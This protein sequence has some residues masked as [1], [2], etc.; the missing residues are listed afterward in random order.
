MITP[1]RIFE[2]SAWGGFLI[3][4]L[5]PDATR[6]SVKPGSTL[7]DVGAPD[8]PTMI[9]VNL[10]RPRD[11]FPDFDLWL[12]EC[13]QSG[14]PPLNGYC[15]S[16][17]K[18]ALQAACAACG[19][20]GV[21]AL[22]EG[23]P[24]EM[25]LLKA[26]ANHSGEYERLLDPELF[27]DLAP[28]PWPYPERVHVSPRHAVPDFMW[29]DARIAVERFV[30]NPAGR[31]HRAYIAGEYVA[32]AT[33]HSPGVMKEMDHSRG[34]EFRSVRN[35]SLVADDDHD[36]VSVVYRT[37][38]AMKIDF[39]ALDL[40]VDDKGVVYAIDLNATPWWGLDEN[41][42]LIDEMGAAFTSLVSSGSRFHTDQSSYLDIDRANQSIV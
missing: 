35:A 11:V 9:H 19:L 25:L 10:S 39:A 31:F 32:V 18:W 1:L 28:P 6:V 4:S 7:C 22:P 13:A 8:A 14:Y 2:W 38:R 20:P 16:I 42:Q 3:N 34:I 12:N 40:A 23:H 15:V 21:R 36:P 33:S 27:G 24:D 30:S 41:P 37:A 26:R 5:V 17:D 29:K